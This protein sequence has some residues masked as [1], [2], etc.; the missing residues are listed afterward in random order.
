MVASSGLLLA[1]QQGYRRR[2][3]TPLEVSGHN[4]ADDLWVTLSGKVLD[5]TEVVAKERSM[6]T[7]P[8][9]LHAGEDISCWFDAKG[10][11][12]TYYD[13]AK[14]LFL[15]Y[16]PMGRFLHVES[17]AETLP[18]WKDEKL[19]I[20]HISGKVRKVQIV[21]TL[22]K[23]TDVL[24]VCA[25]E[26]FAEIQTRYRDFNDHAAS[27]VWKKLEDDRF[28]RIDMSHTLDAAGMTEHPTFDAIDL[29]D[30]KYLPTVHLYFSDDL[31]YN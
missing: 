4:S 26:T 2:Y 18:F 17:D 15:P 24:T 9:V 3:Y 16:T 14:G 8:L 29:D 12:K 30:D 22:T 11:L 27:Y 10:D 31:T 25:E 21:N 19:V 7:Q 5:L 20:G 28:I 6:L 23:Q 1:S 13:E